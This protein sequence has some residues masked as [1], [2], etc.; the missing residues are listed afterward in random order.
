MQND[1]S[2]LKMSA[3]RLLLV[4]APNKPNPNIAL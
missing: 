1:A 3:I 4:P 2:P